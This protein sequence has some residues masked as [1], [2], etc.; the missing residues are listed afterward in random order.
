MISQRSFSE[1]MDQVNGAFNR[2]VKR[3]DELEKEIK[4]LK[5]EKPNKKS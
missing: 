1:A 4:T 2:L 3:I 5:L